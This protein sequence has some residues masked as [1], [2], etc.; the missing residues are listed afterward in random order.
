MPTGVQAQ[1]W[2]RV[3]LEV[4]RSIMSKMQSLEMASH[5]RDDLYS[6]SHAPAIRRGKAL[7]PS[8]SGS[9]PVTVSVGMNFKNKSSLPLGFIE[10]AKISI[11]FSLDL[12]VGDRRD[13]PFHLSL[14]LPSI[15]F[16]SGEF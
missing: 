4:R 10:S 5:H 3:T 14:Y 9:L 11:L 2:A 15:Y 13:N 7:N 6:C 16:I 1:V 8:A 12:A